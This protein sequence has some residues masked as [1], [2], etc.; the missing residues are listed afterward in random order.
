[1]LGRRLTLLEGLLKTNSFA[2]LNSELSISLRVS[3]FKVL[4]KVLLRAVNQKL[5]YCGCSNNRKVKLQSLI[6]DVCVVCI[7]LCALW[8]NTA[9]SQY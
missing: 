4:Q 5:R 6:T 2:E 1:M 9:V 7:S 3:Q 8:S